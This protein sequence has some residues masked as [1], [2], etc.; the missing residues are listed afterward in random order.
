MTA[1]PVITVDGPSG[2]GKGT[3]CSYLADWLGWHL[4]DSGAIYRV[5]AHAALTRD[6]PLDDEPLL[7]GL[8][9][10]LDLRFEN[11]PDGV[12]AILDG[13]D[14]SNRIRTETCGEA[15]SRAAALGAVR[16]ALL[17]KQ[18]SFRQPP[19]LVAD[20]R[21]MGTVVFPEAPLKVYL[22]ASPAERANRRYKQLKQ[23]GISVNLHD[24]STEILQRDARDEGRKISPLKP[25]RDAVIIDTTD[26]DTGEVCNQVAALVQSSLPDIPS[27]H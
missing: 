7:A 22:T 21:D 1:T 10:A 23:K 20:G 3:L 12:R 14:I 27:N 16:T 5:L 25:A 6:V 2:T 24:L 17:D 15:A 9:A 8:A 4:L 26:L 19:G 18:R 11:S 13:A